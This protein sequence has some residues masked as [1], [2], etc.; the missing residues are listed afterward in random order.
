MNDS[1]LNTLSSPG[2]ALNIVQLMNQLGG[3]AGESFKRGMANYSS[4]KSYVKDE[5]GLNMIKVGVSCCSCTVFCLI[6]LITVFI[7]GGKCKDDEKKEKNNLLIVWTVFS[8]LGSIVLA[9]FIYYLYSKAV[10]D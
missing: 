5:T 2:G 8:A 1:V 10:K 3:G 6:A 9:A 7:W 4:T